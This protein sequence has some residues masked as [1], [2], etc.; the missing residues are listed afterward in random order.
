MLFDANNHTI[1][2]CTWLPKSVIIDQ[3]KKEEIWPSLMTKAPT[4]TEM[5]KGQN[6]NTNN[7]TKKFD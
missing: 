1:I 2:A 5:S 7:V 6:D 4:S 3:D